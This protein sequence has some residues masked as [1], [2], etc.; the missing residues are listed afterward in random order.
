MTTTTERDI[1]VGEDWVI[2]EPSLVSQER[3]GLKVER[4]QETIQELTNEQTAIHAILGVAGVPR[5]ED[6]EEIPVD[7][8]VGILVKLYETERKKNRYEL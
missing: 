2:N 7:R 5:E 8:R 4:L 3:E 1:P 6:G